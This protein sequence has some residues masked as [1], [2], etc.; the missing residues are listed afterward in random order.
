MRTTLLGSQELRSERRTHS[1]IPGSS[2]SKPLLGRR[3]RP[4]RAVLAGL[5]VLGA[6]AAVTFA[7]PV[8]S[9][10]L[11]H[12]PSRLSALFYM[13]AVAAG[14]V[15]GGVWGGIVAAVASFAGELWVYTP[16]IDMVANANELLVLGVFLVVAIGFAQLISRQR[17]ARWYAQVAKD[18]T[19]FL[20]EATE[21]LSSSLDFHETVS[22][23]ARLAV[24]RLADLCWVEVL[25]AD[26]LVHPIVVSHSDRID[27]ALADNVLH[28]RPGSLG[29]PGAAARAV[30]EGES[31]LFERVTPAIM[32]EIA[33][34]A[35]HRVL[36][37]GLRLGSMMI[38][39]LG[40]PRGILGSIAFGVGDD[41]RRYTAEDLALAEDLARRVGTVLDNVFL[42][43]DRSR[44]AKMLQRSLLPPEIPV[45]EGIDLEVRFNPVSH[46]D[47]IGGDFYDVFEIAPGTWALVVGDVCGKGVEASALTGLARHTI[48]A[49]ALRRPTPS[50]V[51]RT[52]ND[53]ILRDGVDRFCTVVMAL[54]EPG[55]GAARLV[56]CS[57]GH[58]LPM[59]ARSRDRTVETV[60]KTGTLL[61]AFAD[62]LLEDVESVLLPGDT[63]A[64]FT[65]GALDERLARPEQR[66]GAALSTTLHAGLGRCAD[67][68]E[69]LRPED[70]PPDDAAVVLARVGQPAAREDAPV[71]HLDVRRALG[72]ARREMA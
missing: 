49:A 61:G 16:P 52:L 18:R 7:E 40:T 12:D 6:P 27:A 32:D 54:I 44:T 58:P 60:G 10:A 37:H 71:E 57:G 48:R 43:E 35:T 24:P 62:P 28:Q 53:I 67:E 26:G 39:P 46:A 36:L 14:A 4:A 15:A 66:I 23:L 2:A 21:V 9:A 3:R 65:D 42:Y 72:G 56:V 51:L 22:R 5:V 68:I 13:L 45:I 34:D 59:I 47:L 70:G 29:D 30:A 50:S 8:I 38:V 64:L 55:P 1:I 69:R 19:E 25:D 41:G 63:L 20:A 31:K 17:A 11:P 33:R